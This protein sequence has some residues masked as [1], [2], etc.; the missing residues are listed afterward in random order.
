MKLL[1]LAMVLVGSVANAQ[2]VISPSVSYIS[3][4]YEGTQNAVTPSEATATYVDARVGYIMPMGFYFGGMY[5]NI[6]GN[7]GTSGYNVGPSIGF[8]DMSGFYGILTYHLAG[9]M[10]VGTTTGTVTFKNPAGPQVDVGWIVP[11]TSMFH[12]GPQVTWRSLKYSKAN[13]A[14]VEVDTDQKITNIQPYIT[15]WFMF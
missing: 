15:F 7:S 13:I 5:S 8:H 3:T 10:D 2:F 9:Q 11:V 4:K 12:V 6:S 1:A 14:G